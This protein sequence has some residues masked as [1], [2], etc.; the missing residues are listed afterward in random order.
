VLYYFQNARPTVSWW[1]L[2]ALLVGW[3]Q[4]CDQAC[5]NKRTEKTNNIAPTP[6][7]LRSIPPLPPLPLLPALQ[8]RLFLL[9]LPSLAPSASQPLFGNRG[10]NGVAINVLRQRRYR[11][12]FGLG[13]Q[14]V[15]AVGEIRFTSSFLEGWGGGG[16][17]IRNV[18]R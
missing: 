15:P 1:Y 8:P 16:F 18:K 17:G 4:V 12:A 3:H 10:A 6:I 11:F 14:R 13:S 7:V 9:Q 5:R 2:S